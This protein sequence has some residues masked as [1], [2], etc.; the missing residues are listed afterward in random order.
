M[1][2]DDDEGMS[3]IEMSMV[4]ELRMGE[5]HEP[6]EKP[7]TRTEPAPTEGDTPWPQSALA[8]FAVLIRA[9]PRPPVGLIVPPHFLESEKIDATHVAVSQILLGV[10]LRARRSR[11][12]P[13]RHSIG[14]QEGARP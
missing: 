2:I 5:P 8:L 14:R 1:V 11:A 13:A 7:G 9:N 4:V 3:L 12:R 6:Q 10:I